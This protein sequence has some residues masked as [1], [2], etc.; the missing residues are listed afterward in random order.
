[1]H[2]PLLALPAPIEI[3]RRPLSHRQHHAAYLFY[4]RRFGLGLQPPGEGEEGLLKGV[5]GE[6]RVAQNRTAAPQNERSVTL[7]CRAEKVVLVFYTQAISISR[8]RR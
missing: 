3:D 6:R 8:S 2:V 1:M 4:I 7:Y 5:L